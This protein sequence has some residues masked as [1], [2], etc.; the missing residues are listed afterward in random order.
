MVRGKCF[1]FFD[2][3]HEKPWPTLVR[4]DNNTGRSN[5]ETQRFIFYFWFY[6]KYYVPPPPPISRQMLEMS[7]AISCTHFWKLHMFHVTVSIL[8][9]FMI[10]LYYGI[11]LFSNNETTRTFY[12]TC[13]W[14]TCCCLIRYISYQMHYDKI[15]TS[16]SSFYLLGSDK[17]WYAF[18]L[19]RPLHT[20]WARDCRNPP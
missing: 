12:D 18:Q 2:F 6:G 15:V 19:D 10:R 3:L 7:S 4:R 14:R 9:N 11:S 20:F 5:I 1:F 17:I 16:L 8:I 13:G